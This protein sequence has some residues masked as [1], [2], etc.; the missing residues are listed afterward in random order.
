MNVSEAWLVLGKNWDE[1]ARSLLSISDLSSRVQATE[2][3]CNDAKKLAK[4][5]MAVHHPDKNPGDDDAA[6]RFHRVKEALE[7]IESNTQSM[8]SSYDKMVERAKQR[9]ASDGFI[10]IK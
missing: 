6:K 1:I 5:L 10:V 3:L 4:K 9:A 7:T 2:N 8:R